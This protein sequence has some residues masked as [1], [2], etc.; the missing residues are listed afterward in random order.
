ML[1]FASWAFDSSLDELFVTLAVGGTICIPN[2]EERANDLV[3]FIN[4]MGIN[5]VDLPQT[6]ANLFCSSEVPSVEVVI[7]G[8]EEMSKA[9]IERWCK[10]VALINAYGPTEASVTS[11]AEVMKPDMGAVRIGKG[12]GCRLWIVNPNNRQQL[13]AIGQVGEQ[14]LEG[15]ILAQGY[16]N[17]PVKTLAS[18]LESPSWSV[19]FFPSV[20]RLYC[21]GD[22]CAYD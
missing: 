7:I 3:G 22:L 21:T 19:F 18:F 12:V 20:S 11:V 13:A 17:D 8:G 9:T 2:D 6:V 16:L 1:S 5:A 14:L 4:R 10:H 15:P